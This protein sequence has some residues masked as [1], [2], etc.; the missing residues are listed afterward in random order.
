MSEETLV[1]GD[2]LPDLS[3]ASWIAVVDG[4]GNPGPH[5]THVPEGRPTT[6]V[7]L[8]DDEA[9]PAPLAPRKRTLSNDGCTI[10]TISTTGTV[11]IERDSPQQTKKAKKNKAP[12]SP[13]AVKEPKAAKEPK[14]KK[15]AT[16]PKAAKVP[17]AAKTP[18]V[19]KAPKAA[20]VPKAAKAT[21]TKK[22]AGPRTV[23]SVDIG[24]RN[25][26]YGVFELTP[27][28]FSVLEWNSL[29]LG[30]TKLEVATPALVDRVLAAWQAYLPVVSDIWIERQ[31][32]W[33]QKRHTTNN[34]F[35]S[36]ALI[37]ALYGYR[38][39]HAA[40]CRYDVRL[41]SPRKKQHYMQICEATT[42]DQNKRCSVYYVERLLRSDYYRGDPKWIAFFDGLKLSSTTMKKDDPA[43]TL[44]QALAHYKHL[45]VQP[46]DLG[47]TIPVADLAPKK[48]TTG[49]GGTKGTGGTKRRRTCKVPRAQRRTLK[50]RRTITKRRRQGGTASTTSTTG[51]A[52]PLLQFTKRSV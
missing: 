51:T 35:L 52:G 4:E 28:H 34:A 30:S 49:A 40:E 27:T 38:F 3:D 41:V 23:I 14:Q 1:T 37:G 2:G 24:F 44:T 46:S 19:P 9:P 22:A 25:F 26:S 16:E 10:D 36:H 21:K 32:T 7:I 12:K 8:S 42:H 5:L 17:K 39:T 43:D 47:F 15:A 45:A 31:S 33:I 11:D 29:D 20:K 48:R 18:K 13:K 6:I 50:A